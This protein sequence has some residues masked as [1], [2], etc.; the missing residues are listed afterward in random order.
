MLPLNGFLLR[1]RAT[2]GNSW[3]DS[4]V[5]HVEIFSWENDQLELIGPD[6]AEILEA[7]AEGDIV[8]ALIRRLAA[9][10]TW[11]RF[12]KDSFSLLEFGSV[13]ESL[14]AAV[15]CAVRSAVDDDEVRWVVWAFGTAGRA[16][17]RSALDPR[18][19]LLAAL[20]LFAVPLLRSE[21]SPE[22]QNQR[23]RGPQLREMRY[24][25]TSPYVQQ[26]GHRA[27]RDIPVEG[28]RVDRTSDLIA[29]VGAPGQILL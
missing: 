17:R 24:R 2:P 23:R 27:A 10:P 26:S 14:G 18:F 12:I 19:G 7:A 29:A 3:T 11:Q 4:A 9:P 21:E 15:F 8:L 28:F 6:D 5:E 22:G 13:R 16:L 25:T 1:R 20:N